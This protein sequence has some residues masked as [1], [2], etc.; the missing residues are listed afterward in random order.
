[1][2][3]LVIAGNYAEYLDWVA[4]H[5]VNVKE[6]EF[7]FRRYFLIKYKNVR[8]VWTGSWR[9]RW[10]KGIIIKIATEAGIEVPDV[11]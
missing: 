4:F 1:M 10:D 7:I 9:H 11:V 8:I 3:T 5:D 6:C 2:R